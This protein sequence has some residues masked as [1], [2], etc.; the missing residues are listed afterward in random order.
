VDVP[1]LPDW[2]PFAT[3]SAEEA[4]E[5]LAAIDREVKGC[6]RCDGL[7]SARQRTVFGVGNPTPRIV[8]VGEAPGANEDRQGEPFVGEAGQLLTRIIEALGLARG[9]VYICNILK[10][11]PP[12]NRRPLPA[13]VKSCRPFLEAQLRILRPDVICC[14]GAT[15]AHTLLQTEDGM[16][17]LRGRLYEYQGVPVMCTYHPAFL[18]RT[19]EKKRDVWHDMVNMLAFLGLPAPAAKTHA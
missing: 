6:T 3:L 7:A 15:A 11:R 19:P 17:R 1:D 4:H 9:D 8:F 18:L 14:L 5:A 10:C 13:E 12:A 16:G 2:S